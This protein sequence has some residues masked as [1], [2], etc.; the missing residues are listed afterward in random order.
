NFFSMQ[1]DNKNKK[2]LSIFILIPKKIPVGNIMD[3]YKKNIEITFTI[4]FSYGYILKDI[5]QQD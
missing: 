5:C 3:E 1:N 2:T 4:E